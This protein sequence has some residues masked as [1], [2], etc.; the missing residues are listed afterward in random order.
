MKLR[1]QLV[2]QRMRK[3]GGYI[4]EVASL[5]SMQR[6]V[7]TAATGTMMSPADYTGGGNGG[8]TNASLFSNRRYLQSRENRDKQVLSIIRKN[9]SAY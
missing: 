7:H 8:L 6:S 1:Q 3:V 2:L 4:G 5:N 9:G